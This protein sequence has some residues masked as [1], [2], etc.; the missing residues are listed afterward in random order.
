M[1][2][3]IK[4]KAIEDLK[5]TRAEDSPDD[6]SKHTEGMSWPSDFD[7]AHHIAQNNFVI[8]QADDDMY[9]QEAYN[10]CMKNKSVYDE[11][12]KF[13]PYSTIINTIKQHEALCCTVNSK[14]DD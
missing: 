12:G 1:L 3:N 5:M 10:K 7:G 8:K 4:F 13:I 11:D 6:R 14:Q 2:A 9:Y